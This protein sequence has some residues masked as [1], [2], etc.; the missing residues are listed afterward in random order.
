MLLKIYKKKNPYEIKQ[1]L[2]DLY[3]TESAR[4]RDCF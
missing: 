1:L 4:S 2:T 3:K